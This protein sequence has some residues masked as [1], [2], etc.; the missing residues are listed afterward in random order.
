MTDIP[1]LARPSAVRNIL[2][3]R[4]TQDRRPAWKAPVLLGNRTPPP[5]AKIIYQNIGSTPVP[6]F[7]RPTI[8][9]EVRPGDRIWI[10]ENFFTEGGPFGETF[11]YA[12]DIPAEHGAPRLIPSIH[13]PRHLS[14]LTLVVTEVRR[15]RIRDIS[16]DDI[17]TEG[18]VEENSLVGVE[19]FGEGT[20]DIWGLRCFFDG[21][22]GDGYKSA[23]EAF[24]ALW[25]GLHGSRRGQSWA[26]DPEVVATTFETH[27]C[28]I[29]QIPA[30]VAARP[31]VGS[32]DDLITSGAAG[33]KSGTATTV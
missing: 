6:Y 25:N 16:H 32:Q 18:I 7:C 12:A 30:R 20:I 15:Q 14:R 1:M 31:R 11:G 21:G 24:T 9:Q 27:C 2:S 3:G 33:T 22:D 8:W 5:G 13:M 29:D 19:C 17:L 23:T 10:R 26:D 28:N 4:Q